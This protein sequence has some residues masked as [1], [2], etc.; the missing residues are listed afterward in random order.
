[1]MAFFGPKMTPCSLSTTSECVCEV[2][3]KYWVSFNPKKCDF[4]KQCFEWLGNDLLLD[5]NHPA[6]SKFNLIN[7]WPC[8]ATG[9]SLSSFIGLITFYSH[10]IPHTDIKLH[11]LR[12]LA[13]L[14][15]CKSIP[16]AAWTNPLSTL[17]DELKVAITSDPCHTRFDSTVLIFLKTDWSNVGMSFVLM[18]PADDDTSHIALAILQQDNSLNTF[19]EL[20]SSA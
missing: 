16:D 12:H 9:I 1:M 5:G 3:T 15:H 11:P 13:K 14:H 19:D 20:M 2:F 8:P 17:F 7:D 18:Q 6:S 10:Y 4:F